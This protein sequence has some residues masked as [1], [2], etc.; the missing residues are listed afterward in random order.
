MKIKTNLSI[1]GILTPWV[2]ILVY[3]MLSETVAFRFLEN[4]NG[5]AIFASMII[6]MILELIKKYRYTRCEVAFCLIIFLMT[7][8]SIIWG[9]FAVMAS[10]FFYIFI[11]RKMDM[12]QFVRT[13]IY[14]M[15]TVVLTVALLSHFGMIADVIIAE[16]YARRSRASL[17]FLY[18]SRIQTYL[19]V[20]VML[21]V[22]A[23]F[24]PKIYRLGLI[25]IDIF[26]VYCFFVTDAKYPF[27]IST[28][29]SLL[30]FYYS[31]G[32]KNKTIR[33]KELIYIFVLLS[34]SIP[35]ILSAFYNSAIRW[36]FILDTILTGRLFYSS[37]GLKN[38]VL[39]LFNLQPGLDQQS[40][41]SYVYGYFD[42][43]YLN[44]LYNYGVYLYIIIVIFFFISARSAVKKRNRQLLITII[45]SI[46][47]SLWYGQEL[48]LLQYAAPFMLCTFCVPWKHF[49]HFK[50][51]AQDLIRP[52]IN[53]TMRRI[54]YG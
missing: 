45:F 50:T 29:V 54:S 9:K 8:Q 26:S 25:L 6:C 30:S 53:R 47:Y 10:I 36:M 48:T 42:S 32:R 51:N 11:F 14:V 31:S 52:Q 4:Y 12:K 44:V 35:F 28:L 27:I 16:T 38:R 13:T 15:L 21:W 22:N 49:D 5:I 7:I 46:L 40:L 1:N 2:I 34:P 39:H 19:M 43:G 24:S 41:N 37:I 17:G 20:I 3:L 33:F 18:P 23:D